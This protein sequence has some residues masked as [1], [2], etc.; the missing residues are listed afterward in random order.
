MR[1]LLLGPV[2]GYVLILWVFGVMAS[3]RSK[4]SESYLV[5][6]RRFSVPFVAA[7]VAGTWIGGVSVIGMAQGV[8]LHGLSAIWFQM[9]C[10]TAMCLT[11]AFLSKIIKGKRT[12]SILDVVGNHYDKRTASLAGFFQLIMALWVVAIQIVAGGAILSFILK[13]ILSFSQGMILTTVVFSLYLTLG[14]VVATA[15]TNFV[16]LFV[17]FVGII[18]GGIY[19]LHGAGGLQ[20]IRSSLPTSYFQPFGNL[21][22]FTAL[23]W[24]LVNLSLCVLAQPVI[25]AGASARDLRHGRLGILLGTFLAIPVPLMAA[26]CGLLAKI[27][28]PTISSIQALPVLLSNLPP[29]LS[30]LFLIG[31]WAPLM[32]AGSPFLMGATTIVVRGYVVRVFPGLTDRGLL[33]ASRIATISIAGVALMLAFF[34]SEILRSI[35]EIS[36]LLSTVVLL[37]VM[38]GI[39]KTPSKAGGFL[40]MVIS[41]CLLALFLITG[42]SQAVHPFWAVAPSTLV[43]LLFSTW[44]ARKPRSSRE[45]LET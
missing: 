3:R 15:Y 25:N 13:G 41:P 26:S 40:C 5:A 18:T 37:V 27:Q 45:R 34:I 8:F 12:Y 35:T 42:W 36:V 23:S 24:F 20:T 44:I 9:G 10:W 2:F 21:G 33:I 32:S 16:H 11:A 29:G 4:G 22:V 28:Y 39:L 43:I 1:S 38:G 6:D 14:G 19:L 31:M 30:S 7:F 17:V